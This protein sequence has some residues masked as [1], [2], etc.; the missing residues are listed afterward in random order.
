MAKVKGNLRLEMKK[1][2]IHALALTTLLVAVGCTDPA[3]FA[4]PAAEQASPDPITKAPFSPNTVAGKVIPEPPPGGPLWAQLLHERTFS[5]RP[6]PFALQPKERNYDRQQMTERV[7]GDIGF[8]ERFEV[9]PDLVVLPEV[10]PQPYRR[11]AGVIVGDSILA[12]IDMGDGQPLQLIHPGQ[13]IGGWHVESI[14]SEVA[15]LT[16]AGNKLPKRIVVRLEEPM[17]GSGGNQGGS[18]GPGAAPGMGNGSGGGKLGGGRA[19]QTPGAPGAAG[20]GD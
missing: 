19:P 2:T 12:L 7:F 18:T 17:P 15:I 10:E 3:K 11:L 5:A 9:Q 8:T 1:F 4:P 20:G 13:D 16:R 14:N 6:D